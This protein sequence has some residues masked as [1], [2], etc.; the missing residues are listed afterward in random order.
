MSR[1]GIMDKGQSYPHGGATPSHDSD[2]ISVTDNMSLMEDAQFHISELLERLE[3][4]NNGGEAAEATGVINSMESMLGSFS[5]NILGMQ[6][7]MQDLLESSRHGML[8]HE[9]LS[10]MIST[11]QVRTNFLV[12]ILGSLKMQIEGLFMALQEDND[13]DPDGLGPLSRKSRSRGSSRGKSAGSPGLV[14]EKVNLMLKSVESL[15]KL[16]TSPTKKVQ[17]TITTID[18]EVVIHASKL[19]GIAPTDMA[20]QEYNRES[21]VPAKK[22]KGVALP[23]A[24]K[25]QVDLEKELGIPSSAA[26]IPA[27]KPQPEPVAPTQ[28]PAIQQ[29][30]EDNDDDDIEAPSEKFKSSRSDS[31]PHEPPRMASP[32]K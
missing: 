25:S 5:E 22:Q 14:S 27:A 30:S 15:N 24:D 26:Q 13:D 1:I 17:R 32:V 16:V 12:N 20:F 3:I 19:A 9:R 10:D 2:N 28:S 8:T 23:E 31:S 4:G 6:Q 7:E 21:P 18:S 29:E 11:E